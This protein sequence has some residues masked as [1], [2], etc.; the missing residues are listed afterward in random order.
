MEL[1]LIGF[2]ELLGVLSLLIGCLVVFW[3]LRK[4]PRERRFKPQSEV[5]Y[6]IGKKVS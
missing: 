2:R 4:T 5:A 3:W 1:L 6:A